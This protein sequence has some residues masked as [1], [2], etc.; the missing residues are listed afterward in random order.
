MIHEFLLYG[1]TAFRQAVTAQTSALWGATGAAIR[2]LFRGH[3]PAVPAL[4][5]LANTAPLKPAEAEAVV[6]IDTCDLRESA[7]LKREPDSL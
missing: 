7:L 3:N 5:L 4:T 1:S 2:L 6:E